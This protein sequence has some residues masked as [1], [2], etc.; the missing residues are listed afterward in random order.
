MP[1]ES[2]SVI[3]ILLAIYYMKVRFNN[4][5][6]GHRFQVSYLERVLNQKVFSHAYIFTGP[7]AV[8]KKTLALTFLQA[9]FCHKYQLVNKR[10][11]NSQSL[12]NSVPCHSCQACQQID[13]RI[14]PDLFYGQGID[15]K[16]KISIEQIRNLRYFIQSKPLLG[17]YKAV[18]LDEAQNLSL[19]AA[20][21]L[22]KTLEEPPPN[23]ILILIT[24]YI[25]QLLPTII[26][27]SQII[28]FGWLTDEEMRKFLKKLQLDTLTSDLIIKLAAGRPGIVRHLLANPDALNKTMK[29]REEIITLLK[30]PLTDRLSQLNCI[31]ADLSPKNSNLDRKVA[32]EII[33]MIINLTRELIIVKFKTKAEPTGDLINMPNF[34]LSQLVKL[35]SVAISGL[36]YLEQN[37]STRLVLENILLRF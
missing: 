3:M 33:E 31:L 4:D 37:I 12:E 17:D 15:K 20:N 29:L 8:G 23:T 6:Y 22:L 34:S 16:T 1:E 10:K 13:K 26:S 5:I 2:N 9:L 7:A 32:R 25:S 36:E 27:R 19:P 28:R 30:S 14:H 24:N 21:A 35:Q 18:L 11:I